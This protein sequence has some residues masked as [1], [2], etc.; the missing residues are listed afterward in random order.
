[1]I[2]QVF[3]YYQGYGL[4]FSHLNEHKFCHNTKDALSPVSN[5][6]SETETTG[7]VFFCCLFFTMN[8]Q[9]LLNGLFKVDPFQ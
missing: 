4:K 6:G 2:Q 9:K 1:M 3:S 7:H 5:C 8:I